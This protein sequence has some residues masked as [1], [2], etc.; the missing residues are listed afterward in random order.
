MAEERI[1]NHDT[2]NRSKSQIITASEPVN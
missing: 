1:Q 2:V